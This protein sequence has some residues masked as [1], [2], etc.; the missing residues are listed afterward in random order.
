[1]NKKF[2]SAI[3]FG[4]LMVSST[5]TFVSCKDYD[6]DIDELTSRVD[7]IESQIKDLEAKINAA[8]WITS[9]TPATGGF[10]VAFNDGSSYTIT[11]GK[12]GEAGA[13]GTEWTISEDGFWVCNGEKTTVKAVG[14]DGA[15]GEPGKDAQPEV[16]KENGKWYLW[17][18]T[19][20]EEFAGAIAPAANIPFYYTDPTDPNYNILV[21][22]DENGKEPLEIRLPMAADLGQIV[23]LGENLDIN[24]HRFNG[25]HTNK[26]GQVK[27][28]TWDGSKAMPAKGQ[29]MLTANQDY[30]YVQVVPSNYDIS[31]LNFKLVNTKG[32]EAPVVFGTPVP[33]N[34]AI[35]NSR[36]ISESGVFAIPYSLKDMTPAEMKTYEK[37]IKGKALS[38]VASENVRSIYNYG[39]ELN[40]A[41]N[42]NSAIFEDRTIP[43]ESIG[44][45]VTIVPEEAGNIYDSY[46]VMADDE[47]KADSVR[48]GISID[49]M[50]FSY[51]ETIKGQ[52]VKFT[53]RQVTNTAMVVTSAPVTVTFGKEAPET[54]E[55]ILAEQAHNAVATYTNAAGQKIANQFIIADFAP[56]FA[57]VA[58]TAGDRLVWND[59]MANFTN[60][61]KLI[62]DELNEYGESV[63]EDGIDVTAQLFK[64]AILLNANN[65]NDNGKVN[66]S[67]FSKVKI[68][69]NE[70]YAG[71]TLGNGTLKAVIEMKD[72][73]GNL[74][75][76]VEI[77]FTIAKP[78]AE[79]INSH[80]TW[81][82]QYYSN[83]VLKVVE[84]NSITLN[85]FFKGANAT[86][87]T[88]NAAPA[89]GNDK[90][91]I[92]NG[93]VTLKDDGKKNTVY[94][95][96]N[97][98][99]SFLGTDTSY[100]KN[101]SGKN[102]SRTYGIENL[103]VNFATLKGDD[104]VI[105]N[106][107]VMCA[108]K[109]VTVYDYRNA[110]SGALTYKLVDFAGDAYTV[111]N[112]STVT[113]TEGN[114]LIK[115]AELVERT[116]NIGT[117]DN[118]KNVTRYDIKITTA[119]T[120]IS[121]STKV[122]IKLT[123]TNVKNS[124]GETVNVT[125]PVEITVNA[126][127]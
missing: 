65:S 91:K 97:L 59:D 43:V 71:I 5:G 32:D 86:L 63:K 85:T 19:E 74:R 62:W 116:V 47:A 100:A 48:Y 96:K 92:E 14:Q 103:K 76:T 94:T 108:G 46:L 36:A 18:G 104:I 123:F 20:F 109:S 90:I 22:Y 78:T 38:L 10:T 107:A 95:I 51:K 125:V 8:N 66:M 11:N 35:S 80:V 26:E 126:A 31:K 29:Y 61:V 16:K 28:A 82:A 9:V 87:V 25:L 57:K 101:A 102:T 54:T 3:L 2:L 7:G 84:E 118:P 122:T 72:K 1:M 113:I 106:V 13:A 83:G 64:T 117:A 39:V 53:V 58:P 24:F 73:K 42:K 52:A 15:Q 69:F 4:A 12:D 56:Y 37:N 6:D 75:Q 105:G 120:M 112:N 33:T 81:D 17:N 45:P 55:I 88:E 115:S 114:N 121:Q 77:P 111:D 50:T 70:E 68:Q 67:N 30:V 40:P 60:N 99:I 27:E 44:E 110:A 98:K 34:D 79:E 41:S 127:V 49:G 119:D 124:K 89:T 23:V 21:I 93:V